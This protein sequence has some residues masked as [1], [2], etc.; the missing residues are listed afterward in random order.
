VQLFCNLL[1]EH[2]KQHV[3]PNLRQIYAQSD[4]RKAQLWRALQEH[5]RR[6]QSG[7]IVR[8]ANHDVETKSCLPCLIEKVCQTRF[9]AFGDSLRLVRYWWRSRRG[10]H[11]TLLPLTLSGCQWLGLA[12]QCASGQGWKGTANAARRYYCMSADRTESDLVIQAITTGRQTPEVSF[13]PRL[14]QDQPRVRAC[15]G[16][17]LCAAPVQVEV[18]AAQQPS[19]ASCL[20]CPLPVALSA[21]LSGIMMARRHGHWQSHCRHTKAQ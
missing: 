13:S 21:C 1:I 8:V 18:A 20:S 15:V 9:L 17:C 4:G 3:N 5:A 10:G 16:L 11:L 19:W 2:V 6:I 14:A 7:E 12:C